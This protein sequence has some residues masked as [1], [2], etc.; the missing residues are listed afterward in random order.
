MPE[1]Q[2]P[3]R[4]PAFAQGYLNVTD[5][6]WERAVAER[7][8]TTVKVGKLVRVRQSALDEF[9]QKNTRHA[10]ESKVAQQRAKTAARGTR[11]VRKA[12]AG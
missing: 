1:I 10:V 7:R 11:S 2:D 4:D 9:I 3:L 6:W 12:V 5:R 8:I